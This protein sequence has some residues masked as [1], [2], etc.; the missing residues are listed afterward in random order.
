MPQFRRLCFLIGNSRVD[1]PSNPERKNFSFKFFF[2]MHCYDLHILTKPEINI[3]PW[4]FLLE[5]LKEGNDK[6][7]WTKREPYALPKE[8]TSSF[9]DKADLLKCKTTDKVD[10]ECM[11]LCSSKN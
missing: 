2:Q 8:K 11:S 4:E 10:L 3:K 5:E 6:V 9:E 7:K 1:A